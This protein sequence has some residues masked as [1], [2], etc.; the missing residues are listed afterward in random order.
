MSFQAK[1]IFMEKLL[2]ISMYID[3][4][5]DKSYLPQIRQ[6]ILARDQALFK[7]LFFSGDRA[8]DAGLMLAQE[9]KRLPGNEGFLITHTTGKTH[10]VDKPHVFSL[11]RCPVTMICPVQG[12]ETYAGTAVTSGISLQTGY[13]FRP[14][15]SSMVLEKPL[16][17]EVTYDRLQFYLN[18]LGINEGETPHSFRG[19][20]AITFRGISKNADASNAMESLMGHVG[21]STEWSASHYSRNTQ[22][23]Q[24][25]RMSEAMSKS[26]ENIL[27][28][29]TQFGF[30]EAHELP[31]AFTCTKPP[32]TLP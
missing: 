31:P 26:C 22:S 27:S 30:V 9:I 1:P 16:S 13:F 21:W 23:D 6:F 2:L 18:T 4:Q 28:D 5:L 17:Y 10:S 32:S 7:F 19:G 11:F 15:N 20:C 8:H 14:T 29:G 12:L 25:A 3:R 24:A